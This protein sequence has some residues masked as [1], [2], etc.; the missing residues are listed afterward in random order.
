MTHKEMAKVTMPR[1]TTSTKVY[2]AYVPLVFPVVATSTQD[3]RIT[4][5]NATIDGEALRTADLK[6]LP[7]GTL[8]SPVTLSDRLSFKK[9]PRDTMP[10]CSDACE[11]VTTLRQAFAEQ[12]QFFA[13]RD[14]ERITR[15]KRA[16]RKAQATKR[17]KQQG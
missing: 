11:H 5:Y 14:R 3:A 17:K 1:N 15:A 10:I 16:L 9:Y 7:H 13:R 4:A 2:L 12:R 6:K 8:I